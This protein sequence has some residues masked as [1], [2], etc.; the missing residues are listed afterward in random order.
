MVD[1]NREAYVALETQEE[2]DVY[3][4]ECFGEDEAAK[5]AAICLPE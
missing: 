3:L 4:T 1:F 2:R 5:A